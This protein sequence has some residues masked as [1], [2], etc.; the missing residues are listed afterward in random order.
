MTNAGDKIPMTPKGFADLQSELKQL[1]SVDRPEVI[2]AI[3]EARELGDLSENAE[4]QYARERQGFIE[5][6]I[7]E[8]ENK[9]SRAEV[10]DSSKLSSDS[11]KFGAT[12]HLK[13]LDNDVTSVYTIVGIDEADVNKGYISLTSPLARVLISKTIGA[14]VEVQTPRGEKTFE[15]KKIEYI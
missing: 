9:L 11:V 12:V 2:K 6:R 10:I 1:K 14:V 3:S 8:I 4:Y 5:N 13:D 15:I 7:L